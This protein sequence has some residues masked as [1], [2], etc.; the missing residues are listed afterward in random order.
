MMVILA[1]CFAISGHNIESSYKNGAGF[2][3]HEFATTKDFNQKPHSELTK[4]R[5]NLMILM[6]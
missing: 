5:L 4:Y 1:L 6:K 3:S 2:N